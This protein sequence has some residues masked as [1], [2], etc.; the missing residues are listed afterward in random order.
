MSPAASLPDPLECHL[1][2]V[3]ACLMPT[4]A[5]TRATQDVID[6]LTHRIQA[7]IRPEKMYV[8]GSFRKKTCL[9]GD[10]DVDMVVFL[11][12]FDDKAVE[13]CKA[14][15]QN[16]MQGPQDRVVKVGKHILKLHC[17][18]NFNGRNLLPV[19]ISF[20]GSAALSAKEGFQKLVD[21]PVY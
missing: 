1:D 10:F 19:D 16:A 21:I 8:G 20:T 11:Q 2:Q 14:S 17:A 3:R 6:R 7:C 18:M 4:D 12:N 9:A 13:K 15:L 5:E